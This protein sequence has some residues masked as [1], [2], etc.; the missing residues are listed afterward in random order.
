[1]SAVR[2]SDDS[3][4]GTASVRCW[5]FHTREVELLLGWHGEGIEAPYVIT[6]DEP[7]CENFRAVVDDFGSLVVVGS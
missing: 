5:W 2:H 4:Y 6:V 7:S 1:M 3:M